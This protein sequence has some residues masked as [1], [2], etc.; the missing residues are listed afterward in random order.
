[1]VATKATIKVNLLNS[2]NQVAIVHLVSCRNLNSNSHL[3]SNNH[4][5]TTICL[6][7]SAWVNKLSNQ[8][9]RSRQLPHSQP[10][11][12]GILSHQHLHNLSLKLSLCK[13]VLQPILL[14]TTTPSRASNKLLLSKHNNKTCSWACSN[15]SLSNQHS[16]LSQLQRKV[17]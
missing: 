12:P 3:N 13:Q 5:R 4:S 6:M 10:P 14:E 15:S 8:L 7:D 11:L 2:N 9:N 17:T 16:L 1:M